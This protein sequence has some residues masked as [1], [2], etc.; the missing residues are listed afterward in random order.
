MRFRPHT[1]HGKA[2]LAVEVDGKAIELSALDPAG[3]AAGGAAVGGV[4][5]L[6][7]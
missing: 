4:S 3:A 1:A 7:T 2:C 5:V 6:A